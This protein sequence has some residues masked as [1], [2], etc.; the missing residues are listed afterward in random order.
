MR[1][2]IAKHPAIVTNAQP[3]KVDTGNADIVVWLKGH[4]G[5][6][7]WLLAHTEQGVVWGKVVDGSLITSHEAAPEVS[8]ELRAETL[9]QARLFGETAE[10]LV[11]K[12]GNGQWLT[13]MIRD[14]SGNEA[15]W[16]EAIDEDHILW[17]TTPEPERMQGWQD[18]FTLMSDGVQGL[19][20]VPPVVVSAPA[21]GHFEEWERPVRLTIR[22]YVAEDETTGCVRIVA[23][24]LVK[25]A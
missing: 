13:R 4:C 2:K 24:R 5:D 8:P 7:T 12:N 1:R 16:Q 18:I 14:T 17:G 23:S 15:A 22:H 19:R 11:W 20:H 9:W 3:V 21:K 10:L 25:V 6:Y